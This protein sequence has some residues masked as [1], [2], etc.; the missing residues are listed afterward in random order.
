MALKSCSADELLLMI[1]GLKL[2][3]LDVD[4]LNRFDVYLPDIQIQRLM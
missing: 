1:C 3:V 2:V 4:A